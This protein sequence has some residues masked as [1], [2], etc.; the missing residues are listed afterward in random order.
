MKHNANWK[1]WLGMGV[2]LAGLALAALAVWQQASPPASVYRPARDAERPAARYLL[3]DFV[4][5]S[6]EQARFAV[7]GDFGIVGEPAAQVAALVRGWQPDFVVTTGDNNYPDGEAETIDVNIGQYYQEFINDYRGQYGP[8]SATP[9]FF[10]VLGSHDWRT[11]QGQPYY[12]YFTLPGNE[13]YYDFVWGPIHFFML[14]TNPEEPDGTRITSAQGQWLQKRLAFSH[15]PWQVVVMHDPPFSSGQHGSSDW[16]QW[17]YAEWGADLV[18]SGSD[19]S[20][21]RLE[22]DGITYVVNGA[23]G[24]TLYFFR[25]PLEGSQVRYAADFGAMLVGASAQQIQLQFVTRTGAVIDAHT[26]QR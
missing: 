8:G 16:M 6:A 17:P 11:A 14:N 3:T 21:E 12:N 22:R 7:I 23:G 19:H 4:A 13:R 20:Y 25:E 24:R 10:P 1:N 5:S 9:R 26:L 15:T 2:L 18:L